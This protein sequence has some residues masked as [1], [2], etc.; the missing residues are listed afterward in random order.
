MINDDDPRTKELLQYRLKP[1]MVVS[2]PKP[3]RADPN[4]LYIVADFHGTINIYSGL[5]NMTLINGICDSFAE[6][7]NV[8]KCDVRDISSEELAKHNGSTGVHNL[9]GQKEYANIFVIQSHVSI[10]N[11][12]GHSKSIYFHIDG[13]EAV[14]AKRCYYGMKMYNSAGGKDYPLPGSMGYKHFFPFVFLDKFN[15]DREKDINVSCIDRKCSFKEYKEILERSQFTVIDCRDVRENPNLG[16][17][18]NMCTITSKRVFQALA[19][20][21]IPIIIGDPDSV[22][23]KLAIDDKIAMFMSHII[24]KSY[25]AHRYDPAMAERGYKLMQKL[26]S[27]KKAMKTIKA[28]CRRVYNG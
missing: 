14:G 24:K 21:T 23:K 20:K 18:N 7:Y 19:C 5:R 6:E 12:L 4:D 13:M 15:P 27:G 16:V 2:P 17:G 22:Y 28:I 10:F 1:T 9:I 25:V 11:D 26:Y 3:P 8:I